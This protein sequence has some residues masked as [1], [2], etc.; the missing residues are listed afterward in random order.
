[1]KYP[2]S[3]R[4]RA[5]LEYKRL[6][7]VLHHRGKPKEKHKA[8]PKPVPTPGDRLRTLRKQRGLTLRAV[9]GSSLEIA[10][11]FREPAFVIPPS[12]LHDIETRAI[13][14][15]IHRLYTLA[16]IYK[17]GLGKVLSLYGIPTRRG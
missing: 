12:R 4:H 10:K 15:S 11:E 16:R 1:V 14:P 9:Y 7:Y 2:V 6:D 5:V 3:L 17:C 13:V 8:M